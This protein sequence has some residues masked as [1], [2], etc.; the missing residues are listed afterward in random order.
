MHLRKSGILSLYI[1]AMV[2]IY[3]LVFMWLMNYE[4]QTQNVD[5]ITAIYWVTSTITTLGYG[6][7]VFRSHA[8]RLFTIVVSLSGLFVLWA[9]ILPLE[10]IPKIERLARIIPSAAPSEMIGHIIISGYN[11]LVDQLTERLSMLKIPFLIIER[12]ENVARKIYQ[13]YPTMLGD[14][15]DPNVLVNAS[16]EQAKLF[17]SNEA[18][19]LNAEV[20]MAVREISNI[21]IIAL[22]DDLTRC[23]FL[24]YAGA[25]RIISP[26]TLLGDFIA[27][28]AVPSEKQVLP[29]AIALFG[30]QKLVELPVYPWSELIGK[31][32]SYRAIKDTGANVVGIWQKGAFKPN[33]RLEDVIQLNSVLMAVGDKDQLPKIRELSIGSR[34]EGAIIIVG[35][36]DVGRLVART[37]CKRGIKPV[38]IDRRD[39]GD[40]PLVHITGDGTSEEAL[41]KAGIR[42]AVGVLVMLNKDADVIYS[43]LHIRNLNPSTYI[44]ARANHV[45]SAKKIYRA[46]ADYVASVPIIASHMLAKIALGEEE[47]LALLHEDL[48]L[49]LFEV[50]RGCGLAGKTVGKID[51]P[52]M[53]GCGIAAIERGESPIS[54]IDNDTVLAQGDLIALIG[55][56]AGIEAF[57]R[58]YNR[59]KTLRRR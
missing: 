47:E 27:Q 24:K 57:I 38:I 29:G 8:G 34:R 43:T 50:H 30:D 33:P 11:P 37:I 54:R 6:D 20:I 51:L 1:S 19:E 35:Y 58:A 36:G 55:S 52:G 18:E 49:K 16:L 23:R 14:P 5:A 3:S 39:L 31:S 21:E 44:V 42:D 15:S 56:P 28:I 13:R 40:L 2:M 17:I 46:G 12:S 59:R 7:I 26:K 53:F 10:I 4:G 45:R 32:L 25:S 41:V 9:V 48:E 22:V